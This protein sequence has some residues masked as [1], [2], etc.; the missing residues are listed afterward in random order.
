MVVN[1]YVIR[2]LPQ[3]WGEL[4]Y[5]FRERRTGWVNAFREN[6]DSVPA[7]RE[8]EPHLRDVISDRIIRYQG[9]GKEKNI[10]RSLHGL[11]F[12]PITA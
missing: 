4:I 7:F 3:F 11:A 8:S 9:G 6:S 12:R 2:R 10:S 1:E 5:G